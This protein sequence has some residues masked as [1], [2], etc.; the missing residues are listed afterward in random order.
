[1][2]ALAL[3]SCGHPMNPRPSSCKK[4]AEVGL[5]CAPCNAPSALSPA[6]QRS[7]A[8]A[9]HEAILRGELDVGL[10]KILPTGERWPTFFWSDTGAKEF[11]GAPTATYVPDL[12]AAERMV[13]DAIPALLFLEIHTDGYSGT[14][15]IVLNVNAFRREWIPEDKV[16]METDSWHIFYCVTREDGRFTAKRFLEY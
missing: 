4:A 13:G 1:M 14:D 7:L 9:A 5:T 2:V 15:G 6:A 8:L 16:V 3:V 10:T 12:K 11:A